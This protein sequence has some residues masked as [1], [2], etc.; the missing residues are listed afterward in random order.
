MRRLKFERDFDQECFTMLHCM[1]ERH[2][3]LSEYRAKSMPHFMFYRN[4]VL[5]ATVNGANV[6][7]I[8]K[9]I[10]VGGDPMQPTCMLKAP[11]LSA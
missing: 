3:M 5:K 2:E 8:E 4:G 11:E 9:C 10:V 1:A 7:A 6:P